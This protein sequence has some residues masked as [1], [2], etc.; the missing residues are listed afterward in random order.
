MPLAPEIES[1]WGPPSPPGPGAVAEE[2]GPPAGEPCGVIASRCSTL[3]QP[4]SCSNVDIDE[5]N[6]EG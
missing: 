4:K 5:P 1:K 6:N 3:S 2:D